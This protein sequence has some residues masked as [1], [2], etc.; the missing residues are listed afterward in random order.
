MEEALKKSAQEIKSLLSVIDSYDEI[1]QLELRAPS[2]HTHKDSGATGK[3]DLLEDLFMQA[4][5][6][7]EELAKALEELASVR[8]CAHE[9]YEVYARRI[10]RMTSH[11]QI[12]EKD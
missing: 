8:H 12:D 6:T 7:Q 2:D 3:H 1:Q 9:T 10:K 11:Y 4:C 5:Q